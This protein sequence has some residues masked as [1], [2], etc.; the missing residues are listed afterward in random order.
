M[1]Y[2]VLVVE[3]DE[4]TRTGLQALLS[5]AGYDAVSAAT[6]PAGMQVIRSEVVDLLVSDVRVD[7]YNGLQL[8]VATTPPIPAIFITGFP[9]TVLEADARRVGAEFL[10]KPVSP[11]ALLV[12]IERKLADVPIR[13]GPR[14][15]RR[16]PRTSVPHPMAADIAASPGRIVDVSY[17]GLQVELPAS[18]GRAFLLPPTFSVAVAELGMSVD[19]DLVWKH[20]GADASWHCGL[21]VAHQHEAEWRHFV[22]EITS[23]SAVEGRG[24]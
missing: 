17:Q 6:V 8:I 4:A 16:W 3:D 1:S 24:R 19:V 21:A 5:D 18:S 14:P 9:D 20:R 2:R 15:V 12:L 22:D 11:S 13:R 23:Q 10:V 7:G